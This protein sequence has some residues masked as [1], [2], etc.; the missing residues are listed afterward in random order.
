MH[1][2]FFL[3]IQ[4]TQLIILSNILQLSVIIIKFKYFH[5]NYFDMIRNSEFFLKK[6]INETKS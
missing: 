1:F 5:Q 2:K 3:N 6:T 4:Y